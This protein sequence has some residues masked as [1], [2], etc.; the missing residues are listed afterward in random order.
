MLLSHL[1]TVTRLHYVWGRQPT[2][3]GWVDVEEEA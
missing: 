3:G 1:L 2:G